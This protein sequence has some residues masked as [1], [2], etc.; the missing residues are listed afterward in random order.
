MVSGMSSKEGRNV[1]DPGAGICQQS[2]DV[3]ME[4]RRGGEQKRR[5]EKD[6]VL[7]MWYTQ[8]AAVWGRL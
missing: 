7:H 6:A 1:V 4:T 2:F 8:A 5:E 3:F